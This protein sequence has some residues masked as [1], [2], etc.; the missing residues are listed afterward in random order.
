MVSYQCLHHENS[1]LSHVSY[2]LIH[3]HCLIS[4]DPLEH[5]VQCD[6]GACTPHPCTA[7]DKQGPSQVLVVTFLNSPDERYK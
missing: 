7:V 6:E 2:K 3:I 1:P 4:L 5:G